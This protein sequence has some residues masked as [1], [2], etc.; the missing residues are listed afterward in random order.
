[1]AGWKPDEGCLWLH[2]DFTDLDVQR[3]IRE[4][5][6]LNDI[7]CDGLLAE[8]TRP[9]AI[10]RGDN[11]LVALRGINHQPGSEPDDM[12]SLRL[13]TDGTRIISTRCRPMSA[14]EDV[15]EQLQAGDGPESALSLL[16][17]WIDRL[18]WSMTDTIGSFEDELAKL[19]DADRQIRHLEDLDVIR[20]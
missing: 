20:E 4:A 2:L 18:V 14:T 12:I 5:S 1:M 8:E 15:R 17:E 13:W 7:V 3:W 16:V 10:N 11:L 19:T 9:R 6:G